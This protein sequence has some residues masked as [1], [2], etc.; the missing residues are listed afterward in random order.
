[1]Q[2]L[3]ETGP[4]FKQVVA[5]FGTMGRRIVEA[6]DRGLQDA[7]KLAAGNV[8]KDYLSGRSLKRRTGA[9]AR[10]VDSWPAAPLDVVVGVRPDS[11]VDKY[12]WLLSDEQMTI[13]PKRAKFLTIPIGEGLTTSGVARFA[14][15]RQVPK[16]FFVKTRG[17][18]LFGIKRGKKGKFRALFALK[19]SVFV[20]GS[21]ALYDGVMDSLDDMTNEIQSEIEKVK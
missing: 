12:K 3:I 21:G 16:G 10:S 1:M 13:A 11:T 8:V 4:N 7:G 17:S 5:E 15:P 20:Q 2:I 18:L 14:S 9:L 6:F 19:K